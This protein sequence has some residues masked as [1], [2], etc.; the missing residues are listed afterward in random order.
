MEKQLLKLSGIR[1]NVFYLF[2]TAFT[3]LSF[4]VYSQNITV[5]GVV[6]GADGESLPSV[7]VTPEGATAGTAT[8]M[9]G[10]Y[11]IEVAKNATLVFA[12]MGLK[13]QLIPVD[14]RTEIDVV[15]NEDSEMLDDVVVI[16]YGTIKK[17]HLTGSVSKV[18][19][20]KLDQ[21]PV[22][23]VD[24]ALSGQISG[25]NIQQ[26]NPAAGEAPTILVRGQGSI[27]YESAP[28]IVLDGIVVGNDA[29]FLSSLDMNDVESV[30]VLKD[31]SSG[32]IYGSR[33]ANGIIM[34]T[35]K[36]GVE[37]P[38]KF[39]YHG[40][41]GF[42]RVPKNDYLTTPAAWADFVRENNNGELTER[43]KYIEKMGT[44]TD[45]EDVMMDG[46]MI[47]SHAISAKGGTKNT[48]F[49]SSLSYMNDQGVL[50]T[51]NFEKLN[52]RINLTTKLRKRVTFGI[53]LNPSHTQTRRF[54]IG[55][56]DALRQNPWL[57]L[58]LDD[59]NIQYVNRYRENGRWEDARVGDYAMERMFD[60][61][62]LDA[63]MPDPNGSGTDIS[64]TS[65]QSALAKVLER[66]RQKAQT[67]VY[68]NTFLKIKLADGLNFKQTLGG[69]YRFTK[70]TTWVGTK[71]SRNG[72]LDSESSRSSQVRWH[73]VSESTVNYNKE[74][75][76]HSVGVVAGFAYE[77]WS[78]EQTNLESA[79]FTDDLIQ[80]I[81]AANLTGGSMLMYE[82]KLL[83]YLARANY[84]F[85]DRYLVSAS[86]RTDGSSKFGPDSKYGWFPAV[87]AGWVI[88]KEDFFKN[89]NV[90]SMLKLRASY[91]VTGNKNGIGEYDH[92]GLISPVGTGFGQIGYNSTNIENPNLQWEK[93]V[94]FNPGI[95]ASF[96]GGRITASLD[97]YTRTSESLLLDIP[98]PSVTG[99]ET[100][101]VNKGAVKNEGVEFE[102]M[103]RNIVNRNFTWSSSVIMSYNKN[104][105]VDFG[106]ANGLISIVDDKRPTE[107]IALEGNPISSFYGYVVDK[108]IPLEFINDPFYP[109][110]AQSQDI[111]VRD[112]NGD[113]VIDPDDRTILGSPYP[114]LVWS[115]INN[116]KF[117]NFDASF[118]FQGSHGAEVRNISSQYIKNE[119]SSKQ[120]YTADFPDAHLVRERIFTS[121]DIQDASYVALRN[122]NVGY[123]LP[124]SSLSKLGIQRLRFYFSGQNL[125]YIMSKDYEGYNPEGIDQ[126]R[127][128]PLTYGY[129]RGPAPVYRTLSLGVN[130]DF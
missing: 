28:L 1:R 29:D 118:M 114:D 50:L 105:L 62:D 16:G 12:S 104:T 130:L 124:A 69:D 87:S 121:D 25:V 129:Q 6:K 99:F 110:N 113:G 96:Y 107:W 74:V 79:G 90:L 126:G 32:A 63:G 2:F 93:L 92:L 82:E 53:N 59:E 52:F 94:E 80:T 45:W 37:G 20:E 43:M 78:R 19:N 7:S 51:D 83:S 72:E 95:D 56:H 11:S 36:K 34:I 71:A 102:L 128:N 35:T 26:T 84:A 41:V 30:E 49:Q 77:K 70:N 75:G 67:K 5:T 58:Y 65:N 112:L 10:K 61:Y 31:A 106:G 97:Y 81:P 88:T 60:D 21:I 15:L 123:S 108:E 86:I 40:Y 8:D 73:V 27:S 38:T 57:P 9:D 91:G 122:F 14:G 22:A 68:A 42:K 33:G 54:P 111:Y 4:D 39:S 24:D 119:F 98:I 64:A 66:D 115:F 109:I 48:K 100:A 47:T 55:V 44:Y 89:S 103:T 46:G 17:S 120:D 23:R 125:L 117:K 85:N 127:G 76:G 116:F 101:L 3:I 18:K 13:T